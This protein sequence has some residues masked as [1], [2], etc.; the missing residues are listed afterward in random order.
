MTEQLSKHVMQRY[1]RFV[2]GIDAVG[3]TDSSIK[4]RCC[5]THA[6]EHSSL[7]LRNCSIISCLT[8]AACVSFAF[9]LVLTKLH[10]YIQYNT[11]NKNSLNPSYK[12]IGQVALSAAGTARSK[13]AAAKKDISGAMAV[14]AATQHKGRCLGML[15]AVCALR[16]A[17]MLPEIIRFASAMDTSGQ[18]SAKQDSTDHRL[19][20]HDNQGL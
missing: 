17:Q 4:V 8:S 7:N 10:C 2:D 14:I 12:S 19:H 3:A 6:K 15:S 5:V 16:T 9:R 13:L 18:T 1:D 11:A 20:Q